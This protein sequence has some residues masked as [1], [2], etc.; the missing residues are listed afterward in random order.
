MPFD[1]AKNIYM[2]VRN[3]TVDSGW[4]LQGAWTVPGKTRRHTLT[5]G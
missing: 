3:A 2:E 4:S 1:G 5:H